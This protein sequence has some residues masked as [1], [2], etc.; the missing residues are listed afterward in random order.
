MKAEE[1]GDGG[2]G[3][4]RLSVFVVTGI[5]GII[6]I[7]MEAIELLYKPVYHRIIQSYQV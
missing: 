7:A 3:V 5:I 6:S 2:I 4:R 1:V